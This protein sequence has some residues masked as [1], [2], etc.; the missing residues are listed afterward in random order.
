MCAPLSASNSCVP[1]FCSSC[2]RGGGGLLQFSL[3]VLL[4]CAAFSRCSRRLL[5]T[6]FTGNVVWLRHGAPLCRGRL[7][8]PP[9][10]FKYARNSAIFFFSFPQFSS[11]LPKKARMN[12]ISM[13]LLPLVRGGHAQMGSSRNRDR[14]LEEGSGRGG[15]PGLATDEILGAGLMDVVMHEVRGAPFYVHAHACMVHVWSEIRLGERGCGRGGAWRGGG[16]AS[17]GKKTAAIFFE[18]VSGCFFSL[19]GKYVSIYSLRFFV[20]FSALYLLSK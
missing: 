9:T 4:C 14:N 2:W 15:A 17:C 18:V 5:P 6:L 1:L 3:P 13:S 11:F 20:I 10:F 19:P 8:L 12:D 7:H 16:P